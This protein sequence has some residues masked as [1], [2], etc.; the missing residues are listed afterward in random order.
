[1]EPTS[2]EEMG[3]GKLLAVGGGSEYGASMLCNIICNK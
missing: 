2:A 3:L 1:M